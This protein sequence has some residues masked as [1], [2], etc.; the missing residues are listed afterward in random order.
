M[1]FAYDKRHA[2]EDGT[3]GLNLFRQ[4]AKRIPITLKFVPMHPAVEDCNVDPAPAVQNPKLLNDYGVRV[5]RVVRPEILFQSGSE[6][7]I[8]HLQDCLSLHR[9]DDAP[10][11]SSAGCR[12]CYL[13]SFKF[14]K[15]IGASMNGYVA[16]RV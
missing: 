6:V 2:V 16:D 8:L 14:G 12:S 11:V 1:T 10:G 9:K 5:G 4:T 13:R 3:V 15:E 7:S